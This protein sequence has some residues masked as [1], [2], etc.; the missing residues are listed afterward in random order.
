MAPGY[1]ANFYSRIIGPATQQ[2][3]IC[4]ADFRG[5]E[6]IAALEHKPQ[7]IKI[8]L[9]EYVGTFLPE[10]LPKLT[11]S[12]QPSAI[13]EQVR[14]SM[15]QLTQNTRMS[16]VITQGPEAIWYACKGLWGQ[17]EVPT[18]PPLEL[19]NPTGSGDACTAGMSAWIHGHA[20][21]KKLVDGFGVN[22]LVEALNFGIHCAQE[23][24]RLI[25]P[26][27]IRS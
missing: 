15:I 24:A 9:Q 12:I 17:V 25:A 23:N 18:I 3:L 20:S 19:K 7:L 11:A 22:D 16:V 5:P 10:L 13:Q 2:G 8:N 14:D 27:R 4:V 1:P 6:L 21:E 26:G